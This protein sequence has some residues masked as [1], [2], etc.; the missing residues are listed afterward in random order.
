MAEAAVAATPETSAS[1]S[2]PATPQTTQANPQTPSEGQTAFSTVISNAANAAPEKP[3]E[4]KE[5][6]P[7]EKTAETK[8]GETKPADAKP[9]EY[10]EFTLPQ[11]AVKDEAL[12][13]EFTEL[14]KS[15]GLSQESAQKIVDLAP[16][17]SERIAQA[18]AQQW[19]DLQK[20]WQSQVKADPEIGGK[21]WQATEANISKAIDAY[22]GKDKQALLEAF[23][24]T[25]AG[26]NPVIVKFI[27]NMSRQLA[28]PKFVPGKPAGQK[29]SA[30]QAL[31]PN[32]ANGQGVNTWQS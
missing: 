17:L 23:A 6:K 14:A 7:E 5:T 2:S 13:G 20:E 32:M 10:K 22:G 29:K 27:A 26:N 25:G 19:M 31:Y 8:T 9:A 18:N 3:A 28:E 21:N 30:A 16:K 4:K 1:T 12:M 15:A 11:G 24:L